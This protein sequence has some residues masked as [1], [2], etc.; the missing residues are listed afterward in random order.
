VGN[1]TYVICGG[2]GPQLLR[3]HSTKS[4]DDGYTSLDAYV[5]R[6]KDYQKTIFY[7]AGES[8]DAVKKSPFLE[9]FK[10]KDV[11]VLLLSDPIDE[12]AIQNLSEY[13]GKKL[14]SITKENVKFGDEGKAEAKRE[15]M[16]KE[17]FQPLVDFLTE[18]YGKKVEK[19]AVSTR[20]ESQPCIIST[21]QYGYSA[22]MERIM[23]A[24]AFADPSRAQYLMSKK[25]LEINPRHPIVVELL[26]QVKADSEV[27]L[28][29]HARVPVISVVDVVP[30]FPVPKR[31]KHCVVAVRRG[32]VELWF[33]D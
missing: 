12:Y 21:S 30:V 8:L 5:G 22:N 18:T 19:V 26:S 7:I 13:D 20:L 9:K 6:M 1:R 10:A 14:Q 4:E 29:P 2:C 33:P 23:K 28:S 27:R 32:P 3:F 24:Q 16:Y 11:E 25:T 15:T 31:R 17:Q